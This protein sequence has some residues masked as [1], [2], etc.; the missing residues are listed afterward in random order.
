MKEECHSRSPLERFRLFKTDG[1]RHLSKFHGHDFNNF[2]L[3]LV[4]REH[5]GSYTCSGAYWSTHS[6]LLQI[7]GPI[8][9]GRRGPA[10]PS[11]AVP[12]GNPTLG[13][14]ARAA[15]GF[16]RIPSQDQTREREPTLRV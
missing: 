14:R 12:A 1:E 11:T 5:A 16:L 4:T 10:Q 7:V 2:T 3:G 6:D 15:Q 9:R 13:P 8:C